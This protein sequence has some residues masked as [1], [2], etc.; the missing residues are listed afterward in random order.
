MS[1]INVIGS[2]SAKFTVVKFV[3]PSKNPDFNTFLPVKVTV[4]SFVVS[5]KKSIP[6]AVN[7]LPGIVISSMFEHPAS[8][9]SPKV[10]L[11]V[12]LAKLNSNKPRELVNALFPISFIFAGNVNVAKFVLL[13]ALTPILVITVEVDISSKLGYKV[14]EPSALQLWYA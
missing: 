3:H 12:L 13:N 9:L 6:H 4:D 14:T 2:S 1:G 7:K 11:A 5:F 10:I 8:T